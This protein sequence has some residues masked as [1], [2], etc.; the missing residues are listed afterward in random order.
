MYKNHRCRSEHGKGHRNRRGPSSFSMQDSALV[1]N[2]LNLKEGE[3]F[4]DMGC[5][6][7]DYTIQA[8]K[9]LGESGVVYALDVWEE[10]ISNLEDTAN[11]NGL[12]NIKPIATDITDN[13][14]IEDSSIDVC[15]I[16]TVLHT[17]DIPKIKDKFFN[18]IHRV[19]KPE[20]RLA[21][22]ECKKEKSDFGPPMNMR[23][24]SDEMETIVLPYGFKKTNLLDLGFNYMVQFVRD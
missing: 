7:G 16:S 22:I 4:L 11:N 17:M 20:G 19:L 1:F 15:F 18:E 21:I 24:S 5:G 13:L 2:E 14:P 12:K 3:V 8:S 6:A 23:I 9:I 10:L